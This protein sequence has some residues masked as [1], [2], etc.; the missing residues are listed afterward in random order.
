MIGR[1]LHNPLNG[2]FTT[3]NI[4]RSYEDA[5][6]QK[7]KVYWSCSENSQTNSWNVNFNS[8]QI[9]NNNK[10]NTTNVV[11]AVSAHDGLYS[12]FYKSILQ[13]YKDCLRGKRNS[14]QGMAY[15][16]I[17]EYDLPVLAK[18]IW[19]GTY[20]PTTS[21]CF[22]V[23]YPKLREVFA[24]NFRDRI[25]HHWI[26]E[27]LE[28]L[29]EYRFRSQGDVSFNCRKGFGTQKCIDHCVEG[30]KQVSS[31]Y[32]KQAWVFKG[33]FIGFFMSIDKELLWNLLDKF[34]KRW[35]KSSD[36]NGWN[37]YG[38]NMPV[39]YW[40][41]LLRLTEIVVKHHPEKD[42]IFNTIPEKWKDLSPDKSLFNKKEKGE[43]IG[44]LTTQ[45]FANF[46]MSYFDMYVQFKFRKQNYSYERFVD[47]FDIK[48]DDLNFMMTTIKDLE[49]FAESRL[50]LK[51]H[52]DKRYIQPV[53][54]G[55]KLVGSYIKPNRVYLTNRTL[56]RFQERA[57]G[58]KKLMESRNLNCLDCQRIEQVM[59]S[60]LGFCK[61][62]RTY[63]R[64]KDTLLSMGN[65]F[66]KYF[67]IRGHYES[68]RTKIKYRTI[69]L[70]FEL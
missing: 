35:K 39:M 7:D 15:M 59:N 56:A 66:F 5:K 65:I 31:N 33:D 6:P 62:K 30:I 40:D 12:D 11:R 26:C 8:G 38:L 63:Q 4:H 32:R 3:I 41:I 34:I 58:F 22:L 16:Q 54:H 50:L 44:N 18:E 29:F 45:L 67:Y 53:S 23:S 17:A 64:R 70:P 51:M 52:K 61:G 20:H 47:D 9:N 10:N 46:L 13:A 14:K 55:I 2:R 37:Y 69:N 36:K 42:C 49:Y 1:V 43:P 28:P 24:A 48:C 25:V 21:T 57:N 68:V 60:Y 27:R 19:S